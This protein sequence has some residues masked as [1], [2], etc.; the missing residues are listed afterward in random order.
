[1]S[2]RTPRALADALVPLAA[3]GGHLLWTGSGENPL[4]QYLAHADAVVATADSVNMIGEA[5]VTG[6]PIH[7]F[8]PSG[9]HPKFDRFLEELRRLDAVHPFPGPL[10]TTTYDP[11]N[12]TPVIAA[13]VREAFAA[14]KLRRGAL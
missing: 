10:E 4:V 11:M 14:R 8:R 3:A 7:V 12:A 6:R 2:R 13:A 9:G 5:T 1:P